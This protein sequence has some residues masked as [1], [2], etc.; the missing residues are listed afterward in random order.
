MRLF[1]DIASKLIQRWDL[2]RVQLAALAIAQQRQR[3]GI[4]ASTPAGKS[5]PH[6]LGATFYMQ[7]CLYVLIG[8]IGAAG[9][10]FPSFFIGL[11]FSYTMIMLMFGLMFI[12]YLT[13]VL[14]DTSE[15]RIVLHMPISGRT[16][17]ASRILSVAEYAVLLSLAIS[18]PTAV[19]LAV[20]FGALALLVFLLSVVLT[21]M[22]LIVV[23]LAGCLFVL[24]YVDPAQIRRGIVYF[25]TTLFVLATYG[26]SIVWNADVSLEQMAAR[27]SGHPGWYFY[28]PGWMAGLLDY[29]VMEQTRFNSVLAVIAVVG[30]VVSLVGCMVLFAGGRFTALLSR[31]EVVPADNAATPKRRPRWR[32]R[33]AAQR[34]DATN[35][36]RQQRAVFDLTTKLMKSDQVLKLSTYPILGSQLVNAGLI[37]AKFGDR[38]L[39]TVQLIVGFY[40]PLILVLVAP[41]IQYSPEWR[42]AWCYQVL[43]FANPGLIVAGAMKA[44]IRRCI[45]PIYFILLVMGATVWG[46]TGALDVWFAGSVATLS[47]I[48]FF[49]RGAPE[50]PYSQ[51][52]GQYR[53]RKGKGLSRFAFIPMAGVLIVTHVLLKAVAGAWGLLA[54]ILV[55]GIVIIVAFRKLSFTVPNDAEAIDRHVG[56]QQN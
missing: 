38:P 47:C 7:L 42:A 23:T 50:P 21:L 35:E 45:F 43:P 20:G 40:V 33:L 29:A 37:M 6:R 17:L 49:W 56:W 25:Q 9:L 39:E 41:L 2:D 13:T 27:L 24:R 51:E 31:L 52:P 18:L 16:L 53:G 10:L 8:L 54:G 34:P 1:A 55:M 15:N 12:N 19:A 22:F 32:A 28:P 4:S 11:A 46:V 48:Y 5:Q 36:D 44:Y 14:L 30:P 26:V 3:L